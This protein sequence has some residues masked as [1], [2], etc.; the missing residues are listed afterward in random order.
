MNDWPPSAAKSQLA[1][2]PRAEYTL[3]K[4]GKKWLMRVSTNNQAMRVTRITVSSRWDFEVKEI[5]C[6]GDSWGACPREAVESEEEVRERERQRD[7]YS[8]D[9]HPRHLA[10][11][12]TRVFTPPDPWRA[13]VPRGFDQLI[14]VVSNRGSILAA[15]GGT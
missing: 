3:V 14:V 11:M 12:T 15:L 10:P 2:L 6:G 7:L 4:P 5:V 13:I 8:R 9:E 1:V